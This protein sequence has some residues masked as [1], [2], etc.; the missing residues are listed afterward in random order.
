MNGDIN[1]LEL[2]IV[3]ALFLLVSALG[4]GA[5][6]WRKAQSLDDLDEWGLRG[7]KFGGWITWFL[8]GGDIYTGCGRR[9]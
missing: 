9:R 4:F 8:L 6:R 7:R 5:A 1:E 3:V 2:A